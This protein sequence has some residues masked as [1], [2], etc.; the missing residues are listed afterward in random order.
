M[1]LITTVLSDLNNT[2]IWEKRY[3]NLNLKFKNK[4][5]KILNKKIKSN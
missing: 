3:I 5:Q 2:W 4:I 1:I